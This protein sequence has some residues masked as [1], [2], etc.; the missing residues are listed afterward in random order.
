MQIVAA[1]SGPARIIGNAGGI[2]WHHPE[3]LRL[4][5]ERTIQQTVIYGRRTA[6][7]LPL[8]YFPR[9]RNIMLSRLP[10]ARAYVECYQDLP[11]V[12]EAIQDDPRAVYV[13]GGAEVYR[14]FL[15]LCNTLWL[16]RI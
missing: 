12:L 16:T 15:P 10:Q 3:D 13:V 6:E 1:I 4:F 11:S 9:R 14:L 5:R 7:S 8:G 2:P